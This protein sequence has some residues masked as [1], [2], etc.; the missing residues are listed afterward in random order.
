MMDTTA[1]VGRLEQ[2]E[3]EL[4]R[5][6][7][8]QE[9]E[10]LMAKYEYI[11]FPDHF[12]LVKD[13]FANHPETS[14]DVSNGGI[15]V[16]KEAI[17]FAFQTVLADD[18][19]K[20]PGHFFVHTLTTAAIQV[21]EDCQT[22]KALWMSPGFE[23]FYQYHSHTCPPEHTEG[24]APMRAYW[25]WGKYA[26]DFILENGE[27]KIWHLKWIRDFRCDY[28]ISWVDDDIARQPHTAY[29]QFADQGI[30]WKP[31]RYHAAY[32]PKV[33]RKMIPTW[34]EPYKTFDG[35]DWF[36]GVY[37]DEILPHQ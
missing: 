28:Y 29:P 24:N 21:A 2:L 18:A 34:P 36:Y 20:E 11:H 9:I 32:D 7:A 6:K 17:D 3:K 26:A 12:A 5:T 19:I 16:G 37:K 31:P 25:V 8:R 15:F 13:L 1:L 33:R 14:F 4:F 23:T 30:N 10:N 22:A 27:W 35:P